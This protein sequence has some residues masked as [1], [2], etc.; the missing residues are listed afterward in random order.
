MLR[1]ILVTLLI[2]VLVSG[3]V[4]VLADNCR[5]C[6]FDFEDDDGPSHKFVRDIHAQ[7][8]LGCADCHGLLLLRPGDGLVAIT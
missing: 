4:S 2:V 1:R 7:K 8:G 5:D 3:G 6:H